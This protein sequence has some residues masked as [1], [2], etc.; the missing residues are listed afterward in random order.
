MATPRHPPRPSTPRRRRQ[1]MM[2]VSRRCV[3]P[4]SPSIHATRRHIV[5]AAPYVANDAK[6]RATATATEERRREASVNLDDWTDLPDDDDDDDDDENSG[7]ASTTAG[8]KVL[9]L[10]SRDV[11]RLET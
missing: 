10:V 9:R 11:V 8:E 3:P 6:L 2:Y 1:I 5:A 4:I 7:P